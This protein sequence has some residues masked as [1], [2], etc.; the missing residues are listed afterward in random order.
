[1]VI[2]GKL[3]FKIKG[4][5]TGKPLPPIGGGYTDPPN[6]SFNALASGSF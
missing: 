5:F 3:L 6:Y 1:M 2:S 4:L